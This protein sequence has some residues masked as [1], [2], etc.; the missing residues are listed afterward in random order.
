MGP[1]PGRFFL[2]N[3]AGT[4]I[5]VNSFTMPFLD[6]ITNFYRLL[7]EL[8]PSSAPLIRSFPL[9]QREYA[10]EEEEEA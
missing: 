5:Q 6:E 4:E 7:H 1:E 3:L 10:I 9:D 8:F 2:G